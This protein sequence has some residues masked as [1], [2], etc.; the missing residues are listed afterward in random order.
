[1][2]TAWPQEQSMSG[3]FSIASDCVLQYFP[4]LVMHEQIG[5]AHFSALGVD[6]FF[7]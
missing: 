6:T 7:T 4:E 3:V 2:Q 1:M 5:C